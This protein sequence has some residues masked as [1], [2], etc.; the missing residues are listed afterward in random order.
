MPPTPVAVAAHASVV[1]NKTPHSLRV[2]LYSPKSSSAC[3]RVE[4]S[5]S[6]DPQRAF[7]CSEQPNRR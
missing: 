3:R 2:C 5:Q 1:P 6:L 4:G 7:L